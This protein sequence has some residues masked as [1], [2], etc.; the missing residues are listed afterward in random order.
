MFDY[1]LIS[2]NVKE[3]GMTQ[4]AHNQFFVKNQEAWYRDFDREI[5]CRDLAREIV[6]KNKLEVEESFFTDDDYF[7]EEMREW[8]Q[9]GTDNLYGVVGMYYTAMWGMAELREWYKESKKPD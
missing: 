3:M 9:Y 2:D 8:L 5:S 4:L 7:D 6:K 1:K